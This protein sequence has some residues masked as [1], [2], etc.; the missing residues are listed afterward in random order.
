MKRIVL[1][2]I[3][4]GLVC[5]GQSGAA[6]AQGNEIPLPQFKPGDTWSFK[7]P[8][9]TSSRTVLRVEAD[10][11][12]VMHSEIRSSRVSLDYN[13]RL[14][15]NLDP[16]NSQG[17][18]FNGGVVDYSYDPPACWMAPAPWTVGKEWSCNFVSTGYR[19]RTYPFTYSGKL[20]GMEKV[21]V[22]AGTFD[23][24]RITLNAGSKWTFWYA[25]A[26]RYYIKSD[27]GNPITSFELVQYSLK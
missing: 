4:F 23:A 1:F 21:T 14:T 12:V 8:Q 6:L 17:P 11:T 13:Q 9:G 24:L 2:L 25:P 22:P 20:D 18:T 10:G 3:L 16:L 15:K 7:T 26:V 27:T 5:G 19:G